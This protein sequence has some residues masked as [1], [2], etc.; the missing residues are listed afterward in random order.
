[1]WE[2]AG[3]F[4]KAGWSYYEIITNFPNAG[5]FVVNALK[6]SEKM[7]IQSGRSTDVIDMY[8]RAWKTMEAPY[9]QAVEFAAQS[10]YFRTGELLAD[11]YEQVGL[12]SK[13]L[14]VRQKIGLR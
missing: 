10:N 4:S 14:G 6:R 1:M 8:E 3:N 2:Q 12:N 9:S 7:L 13:A 5:R 11:R